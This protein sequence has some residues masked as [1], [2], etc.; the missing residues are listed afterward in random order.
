MLG[1]GRSCQPAVLRHSGPLGSGAPI[2]DKPSAS[3]RPLLAH[4]RASLAGTG[5][6]NRPVLPQLL[7]V[8]RPGQQEQVCPR[9]GVFGGKC[10]CHGSC[11]HSFPALMSPLLSSLPPQHLE[12][13]LASPKLQGSLSQEDF[14]VELTPPSLGGLRKCWCASTC[15]SCTDVRELCGRQTEQVPTRVEGLLCS[16]FWGVGTR[17]GTAS[18]MKASRKAPWRRWPL[19]KGL[20]E[21]GPI[22][23]GGSIQACCPL[24][25][26]PNWSLPNHRN[27][28]GVLALPDSPPPP[29]DP[30]PHGFP[31]GHSGP[32]REP[33]LCSRKS[34]TLPPLV[35]LLISWGHAGDG[36]LKARSCPRCLHTNQTQGEAAYRLKRSPEQ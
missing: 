5:P 15:P 36:S 17:Q 6:G 13:A 4:T 27:S 21:E 32:G 1:A 7:G 28:P 16:T 26:T 14:Q 31:A 29:K 35:F 2:K 10:G 25:P 18:L 9:L 30:H 3:P 12:G 34:K 33:H 19:E 23:L 22:P 11:E 8:P 20:D 24:T